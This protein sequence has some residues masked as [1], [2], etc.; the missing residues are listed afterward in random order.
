M[1]D[2]Q[3]PRYPAARVTWR[4]RK[5]LALLAATRLAL[6][7]AGAPP[8]EME[9]FLDDAAAVAEPGA[10][11]TGDGATDRLERVCSRWARLDDQRN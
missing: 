3:T 7:R 6:R 9:R 2:E 1:V 11:E 4:S 8:E 5:P 10:A